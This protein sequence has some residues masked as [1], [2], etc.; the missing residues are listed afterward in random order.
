MVVLE[1][2]YHLDEELWSS[3]VNDHQWRLCL[4]SA[5]FLCSSRFLGLTTVV[6]LHL[7]SFSYYLRS[8]TVG[9]FLHLFLH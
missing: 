1:C 5:V 6:Y 8:P 9:P 4:K 2:N 7:M 3:L